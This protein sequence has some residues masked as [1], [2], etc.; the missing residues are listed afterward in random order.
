MKNVLRNRVTEKDVR[1]WLDNNGYYG[2][3]AEIRDLNLYAVQRPGWLQIFRFEIRVK[4]RQES[5]E[6]WHDMFGAVRD[7]ERRRGDNKTQVE[8]F[9]D[10]H[11]QQEKLDQWS[12][13]LIAQGNQDN[14]SVLLL[15]G[16]A[17]V[18]ATI[19]L[20]LLNLVT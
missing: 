19:M 16:A 2:N 1:S 5:Q 20:S 7:D 13:G 8:L 10:A 14:A 9:A 4:S 15:I 17:V 3:S 18:F 11:G 6:P 12:Q